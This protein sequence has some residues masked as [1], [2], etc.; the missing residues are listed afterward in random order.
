MCK[1]HD[2]I[3]NIEMCVI[4]AA[5][6]LMKYNPKY[7]VKDILACIYELYQEYLITDSQEEELYKLAD[8]DNE[9]NE[10]SQYYKDMKFKNPLIEL[11]NRNR[12]AA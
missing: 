7:T 2:Y 10:P 3:S 5:V 4:R 9:F 11:L 8:P 6:E 12:R 1:E